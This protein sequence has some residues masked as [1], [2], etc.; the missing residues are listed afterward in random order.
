MIRILLADDQALAR[1]AVAALL[2]L[3]TDIEVVA[4]GWRPQHCSRP[5]CLA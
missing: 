3:E 2:D 5:S 1:G 4:Q